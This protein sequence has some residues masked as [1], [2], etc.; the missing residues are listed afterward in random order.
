MPQGGLYLWV[1]LPRHG[2]N[3]AELFIAALQKDVSFTI[4][5]VFYTNHCG[6]Y[7]LRLNYGLQRP[8][9]IE[10][11]FRRIGE[12]WRMLAAQDDEYDENENTDQ[13]ERVQVV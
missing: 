11:G 3:A 8:D 12:A 2:P 10:E 13:R 7:R 5:N 9:I 4:G 1:K 6:A